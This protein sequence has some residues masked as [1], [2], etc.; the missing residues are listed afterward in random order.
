MRRRLI[1]VL[2]ALGT[3]SGFAFGVRSLRHHQEHGWHH[4][5]GSHQSRMDR[6]AE[7]CV[8][9]AERVRQPGGLPESA[10]AP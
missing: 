7:A 4:G 3:V 2:L 9:A 10:P 5:W 8:R 1:L 6:V